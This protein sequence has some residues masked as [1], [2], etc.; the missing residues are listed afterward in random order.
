MYRMFICRPL[1]ECARISISTNRFVGIKKK[2]KALSKRPIQLDEKDIR[3]LFSKGGGPGGQSCNKT[4][5]RVQLQHIPTGLSVACHETRCLATN[6]K[7]A[8]KMLLDKLD[9]QLNGPDS[10][11]GLKYARIRRRNYNAYRRAKKK[12]HMAP[13]AQLEVQEATAEEDNLPK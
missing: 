6:R 13:N 5:N 7:I 2:I 11:L 10:K 12:Y 4:T 3:E 1:V 9:F 8:R